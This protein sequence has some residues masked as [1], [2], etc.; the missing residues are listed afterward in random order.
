M[1]VEAILSM[2]TLVCHFKKVMHRRWSYFKTRVGFTHRLCLI[3]WCSGMGFRLMTRALSR[4]QSL[5]SASK[6]ASKV[7]IYNWLVE[8]RSALRIEVGR[9]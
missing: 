7:T 9:S 3:S 6:L 5:N 4:Y 1:L 2:L 8:T